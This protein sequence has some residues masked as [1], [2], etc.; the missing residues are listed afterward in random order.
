MKSDCWI[1]EKAKG[2]QG[3]KNIEKPFP[4]FIWV[5]SAAARLHEESRNLEHI[6]L[7]GRRPFVARHIAPHP[8]EGRVWAR[9]VALEF[10][11]L[12]GGGRWVRRTL[13]PVRC[14]WQKGTKMFFFPASF[15]GFKKLHHLFDS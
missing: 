13:A 3:V 9:S 14:A 15:H 11:S 4:V 12:V 5:S 1:G 6:E 7:L 8:T 2:H 10:S